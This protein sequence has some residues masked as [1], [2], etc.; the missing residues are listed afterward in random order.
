MKKDLTG[1]RFGRLVVI[2][3][4]E[5]RGPDGGI[6]WECLCDCG[7]TCLVWNNKLLRKNHSAKRSCGCLQVDSHTTYIHGDEGT[8]LYHKWKGMKERCNNPN[9]QPYQYY[10]GKGVRVCAAWENDYPAFKAWAESAGYQDGLSLDRI[11]PN[12][13]Y[14][15]ENCRWVILSEQSRNKTTNIKIS[16]DGKTKTLAEWSRDFGIKYGTA[17]RRIKIGWEPERAVKTPVRGGKN[18]TFPA[19]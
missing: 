3:P 6:V 15:P 17:W 8:I 5:E 9:A 13:D 7:N 2:R 4:T 18:K 19:K 1:K 12:G 16:I 11:D 14:C 10:G